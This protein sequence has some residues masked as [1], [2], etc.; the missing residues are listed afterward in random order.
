MKHLPIVCLLLLCAFIAP[1]LQAQTLSITTNMTLPPVLVDEPMDPIQLQAT[2]STGSYSWSLVNGT[3]SLVGR[4][5]PGLSVMPDG[6]IVGTPTAL[7]APTGFTVRVTDSAS[8]SATKVLAIA[9]I[10][11]TPTLTTTAMTPATAGRFYSWTYTAAGGKQPY[12]WSNSTALPSELTLNATT[13]V[14]SG[15]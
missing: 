5:A 7:Q 11:S 15:N 14:L 4:I 3:A 12:T 6:K 9:V 2:G 8:R 10:P 13:G 1:A